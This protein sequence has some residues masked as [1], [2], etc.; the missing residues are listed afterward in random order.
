MHPIFKYFKYL[1]NI[2][3][4]FYCPHAIFLPECKETD[5]LTWNEWCRIQIERAS[6]ASGIVQQSLKRQ[7]HSSLVSTYF[8]GFSAYLS[9]FCIPFLG[10]LILLTFLS[11][12]SGCN[13]SLDHL[14]SLPA[15]FFWVHLSQF[16]SGITLKVMLFRYFRDV[17]HLTMLL[18]L[19][20]FRSYSITF[21]SL[22][23]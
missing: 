13:I 23:F 16:F 21:F 22:F 3:S 20:S 1:K 9:C 17:Y 18:I 19:F 6:L 4:N 14:I 2:A 15:L 12:S 8:Y 7:S 11:L 10:C 5:I